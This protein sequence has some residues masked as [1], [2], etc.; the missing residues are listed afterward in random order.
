MNQLVGRATGGAGVSYQ[1]TCHPAKRSSYLR[2]CHC[3]HWNR[4]IQIRH[5]FNFRSKIKPIKDWFQWIRRSRV[6]IFRE[7]ERWGEGRWSWSQS[8]TSSRQVTFSKRR[9]GL[10]KKAR[11]L[12]VLCDVE[13]ALFVFSGRGMLYEFCSGDRYLPTLNIFKEYYLL[14]RIG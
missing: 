11:E 3:Y 14:L 8:K 9:S 6:R 1:N 4:I 12:S 10:M 13:I 5:L 7:R 2:L